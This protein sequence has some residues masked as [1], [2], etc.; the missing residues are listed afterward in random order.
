MI[1]LETCPV[2][3]SE[4][5]YHYISTSAQ[6]HSNKKVFGFDQCDNCKFVFLNPRVP[7]DQ[8]KDYYTEFYLPYRGAEA[9]GKFK[10]V[11]EKSLA[12]TGQAGIRRD[13]LLCSLQKILEKHLSL[14]IMTVVASLG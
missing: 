12:K 11:A 9:W 13:I 2:C 6:M 14:G 3:N 1:K 10:K 4:D 7:L 8:L 5:I